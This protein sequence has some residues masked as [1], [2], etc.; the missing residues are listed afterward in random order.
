LWS[1]FFNAGTVEVMVAEKGH[2]IPKF[3]L[4]EIFNDWL[5]QRAWGIRKGH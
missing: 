5:L 4:P 3:L 2:A 1:R